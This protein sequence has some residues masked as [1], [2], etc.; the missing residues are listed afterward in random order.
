M[1]FVHLHDCILLSMHTH[2]CMHSHAAQLSGL[3]VKLA[4][5]WELYVL[6]LH[7]TTLNIFILKEGF[8]HFHVP[9]MVLKIGQTSTCYSFFYCFTIV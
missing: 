7:Q 4:L 8:R 5:K 6:Y 9:G 1:T 3:Q 2:A